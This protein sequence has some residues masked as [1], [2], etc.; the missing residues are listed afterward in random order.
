MLSVYSLKGLQSNL[1]KSKITE[2]GDITPVEDY[3]ALCAEKEV[4]NLEKATAQLQKR[5][6]AM[7]EMFLGGSSG[8][9]LSCLQVRLWK[10]LLIS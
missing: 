5:V 2:V 4:D 3:E 7:V 6:D 10:V 9:F 8:L 1:L